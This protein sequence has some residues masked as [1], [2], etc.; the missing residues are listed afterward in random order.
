M[1]SGAAFVWMD[2]YLDA[3]REGPQWLR[4]EEI[5]KAVEGV[6]QRQECDLHA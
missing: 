6:L 3:A 2:R 4:R 5:A 1:N